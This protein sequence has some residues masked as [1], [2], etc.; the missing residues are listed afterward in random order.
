MR[1]A[2][3]D[4]LDSHQLRAAVEQQ[5]GDNVTEVDILNW[6]SRTALEL[7]G[8]G[9]LGYSFDPLTESVRNPFA[10]ALKEFM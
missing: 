10:D 3:T 6:V 2:I 4:K 9:G 5:V 8:Q 7:I 1:C